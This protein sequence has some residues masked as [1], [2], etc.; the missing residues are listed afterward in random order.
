MTK[1]LRESVSLA[2]AFVTALFAGVGAQNP[3]PAQTPSAASPATGIIVGQVVDGS[4]GSPVSSAMVTL[5]PP[6]SPIPMGGDGGPP[7]SGA[8]IPAGGRGAAAPQP[9]AQPQRVLADASGRFVFHS[10]RADAYQLSA[11]SPGYLAAYLGQTQ[12]TASSPGRRLR[13]GDGERATNVVMK[14]W[15]LASISGV[16]LDDAGDPAVGA[17]V[18]LLFGD[19][20]NARRYQMTDVNQTDDRGMYRFGSLMPGD[21]LVVVPA[22]VATVPLETVA[23][24]VDASAV[25]LALGNRIATDI[26][27]SG[28]AFA[29]SGTRV[30]DQLISSSSVA[31][32]GIAGPLVIDDRGKAWVYPATYYPAAAKLTASTVVT[33]K[34]GD[35][36]TGINIAIR[37]VPA[38][39]V[40]GVVMGPSG[41][42]AN[43][44]VKLVPVGMED[45]SPS[46][47]IGPEISQAVT[48]R[49]GTFVALGVPAG[50]YVATVVKVPTSGSDVAGAPEAPPPTEPVMW[51][52]APVSVA[53]G[54]VEHVTIRLSPGLTVAGRVEFEPGTTP[55]PAP[56][57][58]QRTRILIR[59]SDRLTA[60]PMGGDGSFKS[61]GLAPGRYSLDA[62]LV[63]PGWFPKSAVSGGR[64]L[65]G[66]DLEMTSADITDLVVTFT[67][68]VGE[69]S[70]SV[71]RGAESGDLFV[72]LAPVDPQAPSQPLARR[73]LMSGVDDEGKYR[74]SNVVPG[75]YLVVASSFP[76]SRPGALSEQ[77]LAGVLRQGTRVTIGDREKRTL[78][79]TAVRGR[80]R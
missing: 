29:T 12:P 30:G 8:Q 70:G 74:L 3:P 1:R 11:T 19:A 22:L 6:G 17:T 58:A 5:W 28:G 39:R 16:V 43:I 34:S 23:A 56:A 45:M 15:K 14:I 47:A 62:A 66:H 72:L 69:L 21:Y 79:L 75:E 46:P 20:D 63:G 37:P 49:D 18:R 4:S 13:L 64:D 77:A 55:A 50:Q 78:S 40:S 57:V 53:N 76:G 73:V 61:A 80:Q 42:V 60:T 10:L 48:R 26:R 35:D 65:L 24:Y 32:S 68:K 38:M 25:S 51:G 41:P 2:A 52:R 44:T 7:T 67:D 71:A 9:Q 59:S 36:R 27:A 54:D 33:I 31:R